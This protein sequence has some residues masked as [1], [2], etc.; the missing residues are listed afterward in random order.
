M[1]SYTHEREKSQEQSNCSDQTE[2]KPRSR[3]YCTH[4]LLADF[5]VVGALHE[6]G[7]IKK[8]YMQTDLLS[9]TLGAGLRR[10]SEGSIGCHTYKRITT[11]LCSFSGH[12][13]LLLLV[14]V[15]FATLTL[16]MSILPI[17]ASSLSSKVSVLKA[18]GTVSKR[19]FRNLWG[20]FW[21]S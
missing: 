3:L 11:H 10:L 21:S 12:C 2:Q 15:P 20:Y 17:V 6:N 7:S 18:S 1:P 4:L 13:Y 16:I 19:H 14:S 5:A 8:N 9:S